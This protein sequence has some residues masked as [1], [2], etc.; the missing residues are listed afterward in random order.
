MGEPRTITEPRTVTMTEAEREAVYV[1]LGGIN[2]HLGSLR[3]A[4]GVVR[5]IDNPKIGTPVYHLQAAEDYVA[6]LYQ[7]L[8]KAIPDPGNER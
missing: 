8:V 7:Q 4:F 1:S 3:N 5:H 6:R 2:S